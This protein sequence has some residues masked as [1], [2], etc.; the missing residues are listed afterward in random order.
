VHFAKENTPS[1]SHI[2][3]GCIGAGSRK[4]LIS[5]FSVGQDAKKL[6]PVNTNRSLASWIQPGI[7]GSSAS[8]QLP[9]SILVGNILI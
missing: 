3:P 4:A 2:A 1:I 9:I 6:P 5:P 7:Q 8:A